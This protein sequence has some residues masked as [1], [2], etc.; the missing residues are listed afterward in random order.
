MPKLSSVIVY[1][2]FFIMTA[3]SDVDTGPVDVKWDRDACERCRMVLSDRNHSAQVR[4]GAGEKTK[5]YKFDDFG[6]AVLWLDN[7]SWKDNASTEVWVN[8]H[9]NG[10]WIDARQAFYVKGN[11]TPMGFGLGAQSETAENG[12]NY[13][14]AVEYV[15]QREASF[16]QSGSDLHGQ[17][18]EHHNH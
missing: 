3:C 6:C 8:D 15:K 9:R 12:L 13:V 1:M 10:H 4:G 17:M 11:V 7:Q 2:F 18:H 14:Q 5:V 16:N